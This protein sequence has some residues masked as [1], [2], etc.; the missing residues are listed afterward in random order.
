MHILELT[1]VLI[2]IDRL[3]TLFLARTL[4]AVVMGLGI[5]L[6]NK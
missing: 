1:L 4:I 5:L 3:R 2:A 6:S